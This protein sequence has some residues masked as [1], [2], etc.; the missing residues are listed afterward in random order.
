MQNSELLGKKKKVQTLSFARAE[1]G[2]NWLTLHWTDSCLAAVQMACC[3]SQAVHLNA[4]K[5]RLVCC[6]AGTYELLG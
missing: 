2:S 3:G 5:G 4:T 6:V 1:I